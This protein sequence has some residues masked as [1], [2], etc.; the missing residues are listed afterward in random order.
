MT[1]Y[2]DIEIQACKKVI[3]WLDINK[4]HASTIYG[5]EGV[6]VSNNITPEML[7]DR[8]KDQIPY[9][10]IK[11]DEN[12]P[13]PKLSSNFEKPVRLISIS[14]RSGA[15]KT[16]A[17][18]FFKQYYF[19]TIAF[20]DSLKDIVAYLFSIPR[21]DL[22]GDDHESRLKRLS[23]LSYAPAY[24]IK[25]VLQ[26]MGTNVIRYFDDTIWLTHLLKRMDHHRIIVTDARYENEIRFISSLNGQT[27]RI[28]RKVTD[29]SVPEH[30][31]EVQL[32]EHLFYS[33][34]DNDMEIADLEEKLYSLFIY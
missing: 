33:I 9:F 11:P 15:G 29:L 1:S 5:C 34:I 10:E 24:C 13:L 4:P 25:R 14:G 19:K 3:D 28:D 17:G 31:S 12:Q 20:A 27:I 6:V 23:P 26:L 22:E 21:Q 2:N 16:T 7:I 32:P 30:S 18:N 8:I